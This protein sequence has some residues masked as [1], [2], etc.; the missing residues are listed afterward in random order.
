MDIKEFITHK[1]RWLN[2][3]DNHMK[4]S[5]IDFKTYMKMNG[6]DDEEFDTLNEL[7][8]RKNNV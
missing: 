6:M 3:F 5:H 8:N 1:T 2:G 7:T 4:L